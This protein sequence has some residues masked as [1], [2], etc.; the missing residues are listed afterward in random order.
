MGSVQ[1]FRR[2]WPALDADRSRSS[3]TG[4]SSCRNAAGLEINAAPRPPGRNR[5]PAPSWERARRPGRTLRLRVDERPLSEAARW[6]ERH[7]AMWEAKLDA[8]EAYLAE[9]DERRAR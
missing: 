7:R 3:R 2:S 9:D 8:V 4:G 6:L 5:A 1:G